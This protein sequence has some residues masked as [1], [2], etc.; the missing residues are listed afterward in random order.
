LGLRTYKTIAVFGAG[1][2]PSTTLCNQTERLGRIL[3][4]LGAIVATG[5][6]GGIMEAAAKGAVQAGGEAKGYTF[7]GEPGND[8]ITQATDCQALA[9]KSGIALPYLDYL[10]RM[11]YLMDSNGF[12]AVAGG[13]SGTGLE[14]VATMVFNDKLWPER[15]PVSIYKPPSVPGRRWD[16]KMLRSLLWQFRVS[17]QTA[18]MYR[19]FKDPHAA[20]RHA[21][22]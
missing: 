2:C 11:G 4:D 16:N 1:D 5:A 12:I 8:Y 10:I 6:Y 21:L 22:S 7:Q 14:L 20:V 19:I 15:R 3:H 17:E 9:Q 18:A 13:G